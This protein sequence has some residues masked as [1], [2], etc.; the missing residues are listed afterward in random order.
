VDANR[1]GGRGGGG[2]EKREGGEVRGRSEGGVNADGRPQG[3]AFN[4]CFAWMM[5]YGALPSVA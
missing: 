4:G 1:I 3:T 2:G 5:P